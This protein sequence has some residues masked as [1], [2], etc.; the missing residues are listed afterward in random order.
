[1]PNVTLGPLNTIAITAAS[2]VYRLTGSTGFTRPVDI[3]NLGPGTIYIRADADP[4]AVDPKAIALPA[5]W[6]M[7]KFM[8]DDRIG[9]GI[10]GA[11]DTLISVRV[12]T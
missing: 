9:L 12:I 4:T 3:M 5:N 8:M 11:A 2:G 6:A 7:N 10:L 1:M